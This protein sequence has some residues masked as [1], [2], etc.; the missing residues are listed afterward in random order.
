[1]G[2]PIPAGKPTITS[3]STNGNGNLNLTG[4]GFNGISAGT[5]YGDEGG[6]DSNYPLLRFTE[7]NGPVRYARTYNWSSTGVMTGT[8]PVS[9]ECTIP[10]GASLQDGIQVVAN[11]IASDTV[12][13][14]GSATW[15]DFN[16][17]GGPFLGTFANPYNTIISGVNGAIQYGVIFIKSSQSTETI[18]ITK[19]L[20]LEAYAGTAT[21][22]H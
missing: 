13:Y 2:G 5:A 12:Y 19:P 14:N 6:N 3:I 21:I 22:G 7:T 16:Y 17:S 18:R 11:G 15:V 10:P 9:A 20:R 8:N 4:T 1:V